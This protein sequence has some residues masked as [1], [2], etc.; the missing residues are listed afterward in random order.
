MLSF[1]IEDLINLRGMTDGQNVTI[2]EA[3]SNVE[4]LDEGKL[5]ERISFLFNHTSK[6][7]FLTQVKNNYSCELQQMLF[8]DQVVFFLAKD[9]FSSRIM[10]FGLK[11]EIKWQSLI[12]KQ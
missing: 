9:S 7:T 2:D 5:L 1:L 11:I 8:S 6:A 3:L 12:V 4:L 10:R